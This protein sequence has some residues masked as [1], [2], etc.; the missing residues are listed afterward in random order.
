MKL[1]VCLAATL[2][3]SD[4]TWYKYTGKQ[5]VRK[6]KHRT[7][8][9]VL[10]NGDYI[11]LKRKR[12]GNMAI[13]KQDQPTTEYML[14]AADENWLRTVQKLLKPAKIK[15]FKEKKGRMHTKPRAN[16][17][18]KT[19]RLLDSPF[20]PE[21]RGEKTTIDKEN[22]QWRKLVA[23]SHQIL[24][25]AGEALAM[26]RPNDVFGWR[27]RGAGREAFVLLQNGTRIRLPNK[28]GI[29]L[30]AASSL[31]PATKQQKGKIN[32]L[33]HKKDEIL[34]AQVRKQA[35]RKPNEKADV[36]S[37]NHNPRR[38]G[39]VKVKHDEDFDESDDSDDLSADVY[40]EP[41]HVETGFGRNARRMRT[42]RTR[43]TKLNSEPVVAQ[44]GKKKPIYELASPTDIPFAEEQVI[45]F[46]SDQEER[47]WLVLSINE[48]A[49]GVYLV[50]LYDIID[51]PDYTQQ[52]RFTPA[53]QK[54]G[55][56]TVRIVRLAKAIEK[57]K[58]SQYEMLDVDK[59]K[60]VI[61]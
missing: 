43:T 10:E 36:L 5:K 3:A 61:A 19:N 59:T 30:Y 8:D 9:L 1:L 41:A 14:N 21:V 39:K 7:H 37:L 48:R 15:G 55:W 31:L 16:A 22:Y 51:Q 45:T 4:L 11:G 12:T 33:E 50:T 34:Q 57:R 60:K 47:D 49:D 13:Y 18:N 40:D 29:S 28:V 24:S 44:P 53:H 35:Q 54:S 32:V 52:I 27:T 17:R 6:A 58:S 46:D 2:A 42:S 26:L 23:N 25:K 20:M 38:V 56:R